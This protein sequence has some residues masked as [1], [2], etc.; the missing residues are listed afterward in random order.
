MTLDDMAQE[1]E[2]LAKLT[3]ELN[4]RLALAERVIT[5]ALDLPACKERSELLNATEEERPDA[6]RRA[7]AK[8]RS[9]EAGGSGI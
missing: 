6:I 5:L 3:T 8:L 9:F 7:E 1:R 2:A 4:L